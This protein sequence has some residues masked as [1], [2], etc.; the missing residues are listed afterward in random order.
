MATKWD[1]LSYTYPSPQM[2]KELNRQFSRKVIH[3]VSTCNQEPQCHNIWRLSG[4]PASKDA[5]SVMRYGLAIL[6]NSIKI[7]WKIKNLNYYMIQQSHFWV[8]TQK[9]LKQVL[10]V[11]IIPLFSHSASCSSKEVEKCPSTD[12]WLKKFNACL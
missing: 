9:N 12:E 1:P 2:A 7:T 5:L 11:I 3:P 6:D 10:Q 4:W 8:Y